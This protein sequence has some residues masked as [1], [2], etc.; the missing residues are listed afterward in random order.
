MPESSTEFDSAGAPPDSL[1]AVLLAEPPMRCLKCGAMSSLVPLTA[2]FCPQCG[3]TLDPP[4]DI[5]LPP[6]QSRALS[7]LRAAWRVG[8]LETFHLTRRKSRGI[9]P[10]QR[11]DY[12]T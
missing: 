8:V 11:S 2:R 6:G 12:A 4:P 10:M 9:G 5:S 3:A 1:V 7:R